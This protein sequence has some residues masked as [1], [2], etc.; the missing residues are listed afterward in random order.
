MRKAFRYLIILILLFWLGA[1][2]VV[3]GQGI[4]GIGGAPIGGTGGSGSGGG[5]STTIIVN[6]NY[7]VATGGTN[8]IDT[9]D[10]AFGT[11]YTNNS[12]SNLLVLVSV[13]QPTAS[14][15]SGIYID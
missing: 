9:T 3:L 2:A 11:V 10:L 12:G 15:Y 1:L 14:N 13:S 7:S 8:T 5:G 6:N 4:G